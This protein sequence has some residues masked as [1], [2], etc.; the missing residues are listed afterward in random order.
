MPSHKRPVGEAA[1]TEAEVVECLLEKRTMI[2]LT[3]AYHVAL[4]HYVRRRS[5]DFD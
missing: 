5:T 1:P 2:N 4:K 3:I